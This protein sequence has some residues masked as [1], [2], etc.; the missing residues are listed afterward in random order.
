[1]EENEEMADS[2]APAST[3]P[4]PEFPC[5]T[6]FFQPFL[7]LPKIFL[8]P[9]FADEGICRNIGLDRRQG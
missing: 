9:L 1:M 2:P 3:V 5:P 6:L 8:R 4:R 7:L